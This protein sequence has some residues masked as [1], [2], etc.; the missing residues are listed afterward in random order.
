MNRASIRRTVLVLAL[1]AAGCAHTPGARFYTL[2][3]RAAPAASESADASAALVAVAPTTL[4][5]HVDRPEI[6]TVGGPNESAIHDFDRWVG[7]LGKNFSQT[8]VEDLAA[9]LP[10]DRYVVV[11]WNASSSADARPAIR[12]SVTVTRFDLRAGA[13]GAAALEAGWTL[14]APGGKVLKIDKTAKTEAAQGK[15]IKDSVAA[16]SRCVA[17]LGEDIAADIEAAR[18]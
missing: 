17:E 5:E 16:M 2:S 6:V 10:A 1:A 8:L 18:R 9:Q 13:Q 7:D 11:Q 4:P 12:L 3:T 15:T 14:Q